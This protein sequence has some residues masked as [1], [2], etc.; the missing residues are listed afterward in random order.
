VFGLGLALLA[1]VIISAQFKRADPIRLRDEVIVTIVGVIA[2]FCLLVGYRLLLNRP[3]RFGSLLTPVA[4]QILGVCLAARAAAMAVLCIAQGTYTLILGSVLLGCL[5][6][7]CIVAGRDLR[8][9]AASSRVFPPETSLLR[10]EGFTP[11]GFRCGIEIL[12]DDRTPMEFVVAVLTE[13]LGFNQTDAI[14]TMLYIHQNGGVLLSRDS[15]EEAT[16]VA[17]AVAAEARAQNHPLV[18]RAVSVEESVAS[19]AS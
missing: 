5:A 14:R 17:E 16:R 7:G 1:G 10:M 6:Y 3:N 9:P 12:N 19:P 2:A 8:A 4:W 13:A 11:A 15:P 18:C